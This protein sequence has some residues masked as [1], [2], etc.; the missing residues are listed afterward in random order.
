MEREHNIAGKNGY[1]LMHYEIKGDGPVM[2]LLHGMS[3]SH[4]D[5]RLLWP[6]LVKAGYRVVL[7]DL[8]GHGDSAKPAEARLYT[9]KALFAV[10]ADWI[11]YLG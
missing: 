1:D 6:K 10:L 2:I 8:L 9:T 7:A 11:D 4:K 3:T 5:W